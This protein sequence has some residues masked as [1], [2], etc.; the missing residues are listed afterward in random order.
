MMN[1]VVKFTE[2]ELAYICTLITGKVIKRYFQKNSQEFTQ[3][4]PG[5]RPNRISDEEAIA[6]AVR[7]KSKPFVLSFLNRHIKDWIDQINTHKNNLIEE[8]KSPEAALLL[9]LPETVFCGRLDIYFKL[10]EENYTQEYIQLAKCAVQLI[11]VKQEKS[12]LV[13]NEQAASSDFSMRDEQSYVA[14]KEWEISEKNYVYK[15]GML[16]SAIE[17]KQLA[18]DEAQKK[19]AIIQAKEVDLETEIA[20]L[21]KL[22]KNSVFSDEI[23]R[24]E[25]YP[26]TSLCVVGFDHEGRVRLNRLSDIKNGVILGNYLPD[27]PVYS[28]LFT[29]DSSY[30]EGFVGI[31]DWGVIPNAS[32]SMKDYIK[33]SYNDKYAPI[34]IVILRDC[35][36]MK[37][38]LEQLKQGTSGVA[39]ASKVIF[40]YWNEQGNYEGIFCTPKCLD[41]SENKIKLKDNVFSLP[42]FVFTDTDM[43]SV[44][45]RFFHRIINIGMPRKIVSIK[46]PLEI[47]KTIIVKRVTWTAL[48]QKGFTKSEYQRIKGLLYELPTDNLYQEIADACECGVME[49]RELVEQ[50]IQSADT[51]LNAS[52]IEGEVLVHL[53]QNHPALM[54]NC[55]NELVYEWKVENASQI[56]EAKIALEC[57][58]E[59]NS[60]QLKIFEQLS[61]EYAATQMKLDEAVDK[62]G[63]QEQLADDVTKKVSDRIELA[64]KNA[65]DFI[66]ELAFNQPFGGDTVY[67]LKTTSATATFIAGTALSEEELDSNSNWSELQGTIKDELFEA[68]V[69]EKYVSGLAAYMYSAYVSSIPLLLAGPGAHDIADAFSVAL[70]GRLAATLNFDGEYNISVVEQCYTSEDKVIVI[71]NP[72]NNAW[73]RYLTRIVSD[74]RKFYIVTNPYPE[75]LLIEPNSLFTYMLPMLTELLVNKLPRRNFVGGYMHKEFCGYHS[76]EIKPYYGKLLDNMKVGTLVKKQFQQVITDMH[77]ILQDNNADYDCIFA[78][79]PYAYSC[80]KTDVFSE[81]FVKAAQRDMSISDDLFDSLS[82]Y[83]GEIE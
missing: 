71:E 67:G 45:E 28:R 72:F 79:L 18:L 11:A 38:L 29:K 4:R 32:D 58:Q 46:D 15:V 37:E 23:N 59:K 65:A 60:E 9:M 6:L 76:A 39:I 10:V 22:E 80:E 41:V 17:E 77:I 1:Y 33:S 73:N 35:E 57:I 12:N 61:E 51:Y 13:L 44:N 54:E 48:K 81:Q 21:H 52:D 42:M 83:L 66:T 49:A 47:V 20:E 27:I 14:K 70:F 31:W 19:L 3:M 68:G 43:F 34:E 56:A 26:F 16:K 82:M 63:Q 2:E 8:G 74:K 7:Y 36:T 24:N 5:F 62:L 69:S 55:K 50:F 30:Q 25:E 40:A 75:D 78:L 64:R 53:I